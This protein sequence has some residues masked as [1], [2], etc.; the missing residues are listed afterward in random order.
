MP[1]RGRSAKAL[2]PVLRQRSA[3]PSGRPA[4][5]RLILIIGGGASGKSQRA[6]EFAGSTGRRAFVATAQALDDEMVSR[7]RRHRGA[8]GGGWTTE[9]IPIELVRWFEKERHK[10]KVVVLDCLTLWLSNLRRHGASEKEV[11]QRTLDL[12]RAVRQSGARIIVVTNEVGMSLVPM[13]ARSRQFRDLAGAINQRF[14]EAADEVHV[15]VAGV[16]VRIK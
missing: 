3:G 9:E 13:E 4:K 14:A 2:P 15:V 1:A 16:T 8:R 7:I 5:N 12:I 6:L 10:Y 11:I